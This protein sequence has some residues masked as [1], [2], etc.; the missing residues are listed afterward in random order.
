M[1]FFSNVIGF[2]GLIFLAAAVN[3]FIFLRAMSAADELYQ[4]MRFTSSTATYE[5][6]V[7]KMKKRK[8]N[9]PDKNITEMR[10][11]AVTW[12]TR[13]VNV[14]G[15]FPLLG[16]MGTVISLIMITDGGDMT[17]EFMAALTST[18]WGLVF[19]VFFRLM[20]TR[21]SSRLEIG[22][23][24]ADLEM[25]RDAADAARMSEKEQTEL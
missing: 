22:E 3:L 1:V 16:I 5:A 9:N 19:A 13:Y 6:D 14:T 20:D 17:G 2:D 7:K 25:E 18:F 24:L 10:T 4:S 11:N 15:I 12:Y 21:V 8:R 23:E